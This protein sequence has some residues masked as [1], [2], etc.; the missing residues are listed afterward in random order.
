MYCV[1][2]DLKQPA[3]EDKLSLPRVNRPEVCFGPCPPVGTLHRY[4]WTIEA[5]DKSGKIIT[6]TAPEGR[7]PVR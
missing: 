1:I 6:R 3:S 5:L 4:V 2:D 7:F